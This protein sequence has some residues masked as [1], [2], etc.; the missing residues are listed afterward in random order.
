MT[1]TFIILMFIFWALNYQ[2]AAAG[3]RGMNPFKLGASLC[4]ILGIIFTLAGCIW[5]LGFIWGLIAAAFFI[6][7]GAHQTLGWLITIPVLVTNNLSTIMLI[8]RWYIYMFGSFT[9]ICLVF[10]IISFFITPFQGLKVEILD[11]DNYWIYLAVLF[12]GLIISLIVA[13]AVGRNNKTEDI[14]DEMN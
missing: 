3:A 12:I 10:I 14:F 6:L 7:G 2:S 11:L 9:L 8:T 1:I 4:S 5:Y 13:K